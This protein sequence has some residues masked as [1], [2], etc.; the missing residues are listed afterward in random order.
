MYLNGVSENG[1]AAG[2]ASLAGDDALRTVYYD[3]TTSRVLA[4]YPGARDT[5][6]TDVNDAGRVVG[7]GSVGLLRG[8]V[9]GPD[10][11][12][13]VAL[14]TLGGSTSS[15][16][17]INNAGR[18]VGSAGDAANVTRATY[19]DLTAG[20]SYGGPVAI[21]GLG[22]AFSRASAI[23][24]S[25]GVAGN[26]SVGSMTVPFFWSGIAGQDP[27]FIDLLSSLGTSAGGIGRG[28]NS[29]GQVVGVQGGIIPGGYRNRAFIW[30]AAAG[31]RALDELVSGW[32]FSTRGRSTTAARSSPT[33]SGPAQASSSGCS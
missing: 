18:V 27:T 15:A 22:S 1:R 8:F 24:E 31:T 10:G 9:S 21:G 16:E 25:G 26:V 23:S 32:T 17:A 33:V 19:W 3:G 28:V 11:G 12:P 14:G 7:N 30:D 2:Y 20:G 6:A 4:A 29:L 13:L 5:Y